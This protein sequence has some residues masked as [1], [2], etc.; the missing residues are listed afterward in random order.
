MRKVL[1]YRHYI[2]IP[3]AILH[4][5]PNILKSKH[6]QVQTYPSPNIPKSKH[7]EVQTYPIPTTRSHKC[8]AQTAAARAAR[9]AAVACSRLEEPAA[10]LTKIRVTT[11]KIWPVGS[12]LR[13]SHP[14]T[15]LMNGMFPGRLL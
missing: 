4:T 6:T 11:E 9:Y 3:R 7:T 10:N 12:R 5:S 8:C 14:K 1:D 13:C 2:I 15:R